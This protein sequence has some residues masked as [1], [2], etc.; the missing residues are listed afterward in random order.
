LEGHADAINSVAYSFEGQYIVS[1]S[2][3]NTVKLWSASEGKLIKKLEGHQTEI[4]SA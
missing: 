3:D 2:C 1:G 4:Y